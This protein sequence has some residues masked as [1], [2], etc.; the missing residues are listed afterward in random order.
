MLLQWTTLGKKFL[1][2]TLRPG[3][4]SWRML[5][6]LACVHTV[7]C[8]WH[9]P[10]CQDFA[11]ATACFFVHVFDHSP[12]I[13]PWLLQDY[14]AALRYYPFLL[15]LRI[16]SLAALQLTVTCDL[17]H[18]VEHAPA[19]SCAVRK[20]ACAC[21]WCVHLRLHP[22]ALPPHLRHA[23]HR[24]AVLKDCIVHPTLVDSSAAVS[25][26]QITPM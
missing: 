11:R 1:K 18:S 25:R 12:P 9:A 13:P 10:V 21:V 14:I 15:L 19:L 24:H 2:L 23:N 22:L 5:P 26:T 16:G 8:P 17:I 7:G 6:G 20:C 3:P 4:S